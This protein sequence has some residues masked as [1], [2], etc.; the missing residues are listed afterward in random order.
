MLATLVFIWV[1]EGHLE[2]FIRATE[3][4]HIHSIKE[5]GNLRFDVLQNRE[6]RNRFTLFEVY[7]T[8]R[9]AAEHKKTDHYLLWK[10]TVE[11]W[12]EK[13]RESMAHYVIAP[14]DLALWK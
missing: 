11:P 6:D 4:N 13:P 5:P 8:E 9:D 3:Q 1:K 7:R 10:K 14:K 12:M 2:E